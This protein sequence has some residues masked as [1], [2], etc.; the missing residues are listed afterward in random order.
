M[1]NNKILNILIIE[2]DAVAC[3]ELSVYIEKI[4]TLKLIGITNSTDEG[5]AIVKSELPDVVI[6]GMELHQGAGNG[7]SFLTKLK[8]L[9]LSRC[10]YILITTNNCSNLTY[11]SARQLGA[12]FIM[13]KYKSDYSAQNVVEFIRMIQPTLLTRRDSAPISLPEESHSKETAKNIPFYTRRI[14]RELDLIGISPKNIGYGYLADAILLIMENPSANVY[15]E[16]AQKYKKSDASVERAMQNAINRA[17]RVSGIEELL[18]HYTAKIHSEKGVPTTLE[19][20]Y[21]YA[22]KIRINL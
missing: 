11:V 8:E 19:F 2:D 16:L 13:S 17:W 15:K 21:Y 3:R 5:L 9:Q 20:V 22:N 4:D 10:P 6:L 7:I 14:Y 12:D 1:M 18:T